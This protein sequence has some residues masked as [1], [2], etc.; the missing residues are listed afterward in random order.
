MHADPPEL[1]DV[2]KVRTPQQRF[3]VTKYGINMTGMPGFALA[4]AKDD[5]LWKV[6]VH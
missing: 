1:K 6:V 2:V 5:D 3:R 4:G